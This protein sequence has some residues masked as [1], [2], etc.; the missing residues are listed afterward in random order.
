MT[1]ETQT[2]A[3][4]TPGARS[5]GRG[6]ARV[7]RRQ[8]AR[9]AQRDGGPVIG[10]NGEVLTRRRVGGIDQFHI[11]EELI[12]KGWT[13]Q[14]NTVTIYNN[15]DLVI[16]QQMQ[17]Y[18]N[19]WRPVPA[20]RHPGKFVPF[21]KTGDIIRDGMRLEERPEVLTEEAREED[22]RVA[23]QQMRDRDQSLMGGKANLRK[24]MAGGFEMDQKRYR[25]TGG[26]LKMSIDPGID[27]PTPQHRVAGADE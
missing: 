3:F 15:P 16:G 25:G 12:P 23:Y 8:P 9:D 1:D 18:E 10:H 21:G 14:W 4:S 13:Y 7:Q 5:Q 22:Q 2:D 26:D 11:P 6:A 20:E 24:N 27:I 19:G 17:M